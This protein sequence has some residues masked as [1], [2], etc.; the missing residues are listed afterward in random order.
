MR[1]FVGVVPPW[2]IIESLREIKR[3]S[4]DGVRWTPENN[5]HITLRFLGEVQDPGLTIERLFQIKYP[6]LEVHLGPQTE[7]LNR[8][9]LYLPVHG[10]AELATLVQ[11]ATADI[12]TPS[13]SHGSEFL[14]HLTLAR[15]KSSVAGLRHAAGIPFKATWTVKEFQLIQSTVSNQGSKY[16]PLKIFPLQRATG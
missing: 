14:G 2:E 5:W 6:P 7:I 3:P 15:V 8:R 4:I 12:E 1:L 16:T 9:I 13:A 11:N 10:L